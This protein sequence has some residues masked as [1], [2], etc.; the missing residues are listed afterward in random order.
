MVD[1]KNTQSSEYDSNWRKTTLFIHSASLP[2][3]VE[4]IK[5]KIN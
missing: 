2:T 1:D 4:Q 3:A 5:Q